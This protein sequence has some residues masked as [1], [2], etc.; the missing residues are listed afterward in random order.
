[1]KKYILGIV[2]GIISC[3]AVMTVVSFVMD[4]NMKRYSDKENHYYEKNSDSE[5]SIPRFCNDTD[6]DI[7]TQAEAIV[8]GTKTDASDTETGMEK[9]MEKATPTDSC[10]EG[11]FVKESRGYL[12][13]CHRDGKIYDFTN[14]LVD[15]LDVRTKKL[16][17]EQISFKNVAELYAFL[18]SCTS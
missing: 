17:K 5:E 2:Y 8:N 16:V 9:D 1:M 7:E 12:V 11:F 14:I 18:E 6:N 15:N 4:K 10:P 3:A 13:I